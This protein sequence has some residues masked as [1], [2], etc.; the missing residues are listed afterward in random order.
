MHESMSVDTNSSEKIQRSDELP[1]P[2]DELA[3]AMNLLF[4]HR[5]M[6]IKNIDNLR[7]QFMLSDDFG[8]L[9]NLPNF[10]KRLAF[11]NVREDIREVFNLKILALIQDLNTGREY[12]H[13]ETESISPNIQKLFKDGAYQTFFAKD[14]TISLETPLTHLELRD[15]NAAFMSV[16]LRDYILRHQKDQKKQK[17]AFLNLFKHEYIYFVDDIN[18]VLTDVAQ[19]CSLYRFERAILILKNHEQC[20]RNKGLFLTVGLII[21]GGYTPVHHYP[22]EGSNWRLR[23]R[24]KLI[25]YLGKTPASQRNRNAIFTQPRV[26]ESIHINEFLLADDFEYLEDTVSFIK[27][28]T[29]RTK[30]DIRDFLAEKLQEFINQ[31]TSKS[32]NFYTQPSHASIKEVLSTEACKVF[33]AFVNQHVISESITPGDRTYLLASFIGTY[34][35]VFFL[36]HKHDNK[37]EKQIFLDK[38]KGEYA[39]ILQ[40]KPNL[41]QEDLI[42]LFR[43]TRTLIELKK[44]MDVNLNKKLFLIIGGILEGRVGFVHQGYFTGRPSTGWETVAR[45]KLI[46]IIF[47]IQPVKRPKQNYDN[48]VNS[49][50]PVLLPTTNQEEDNF[51]LWNNGILK[52]YWAYQ[53]A[54]DIGHEEQANLLKSEL[55]SKGEYN[56]LVNNEHYSTKEKFQKICLLQLQAYQAKMR[57]LMHQGTLGFFSQLEVYLSRKNKL[58]EILTQLGDIP[59][60]I[61]ANTNQF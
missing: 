23:C 55:I 39:P 49:P 14:T 37:N 2:H 29:M 16:Y 25:E 5:S 6:D 52:L 56:L 42:Y 21:E 51:R 44:C 47:D 40:G 53:E 33:F 4:L 38:L 1:T 12:G 28:L 34:L 35:R 24:S 45:T 20:H 8:Y 58:L 54:I 15:L 59:S 7:N 30:H 57:S 60:V 10:L 43:F 32:A 31:I 11:L 41:S 61:I 50:A 17:E 46:E 13:I 48:H 26:I 3:A 18:R 9:S 19:F 27:Q 22:R 36:H